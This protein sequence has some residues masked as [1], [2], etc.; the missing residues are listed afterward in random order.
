[1]VHQMKAFYAFLKISDLR[2]GSRDTVAVLKRANP[3]LT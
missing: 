3:D 1:M 2:E